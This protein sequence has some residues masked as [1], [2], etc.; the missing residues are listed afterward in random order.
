[1]EI[2]GGSIFKIQ[3]T[4]LKVSQEAERLIPNN[5]RMI[6][7]VKLLSELT[8]CIL[9]SQEK[10]EIA[11]SAL[12]ELRKHNA[13][14]VPQTKNEF[15]KV[16]TRIKSILK[17]PVSFKLNKKTYTRRLRFFN[18]KSDNII[19]SIQSIYLNKYKIKE[20]LK[21]HSNTHDARKAIIKHT[22]GLGPK[23]ASMFLRNI[24]FKGEFAVLDKHVIDYMKMLGLTNF[25]IPSFSNLTTYQTVEN[26]LKVYAS[27]YHLSLRHLDLGIWTTM[28]NLK[29]Y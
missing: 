21:D 20:I 1:M 11:I 28:R 15:Y 23:Q 19:K 16:K 18:K 27:T 17:N 6:S 2:V 22:H 9:S 10:Y 26:I 12:R 7:E 8:L 29:Y 14:F 3:D 13:L 5:T 25:S 4:V 24:G